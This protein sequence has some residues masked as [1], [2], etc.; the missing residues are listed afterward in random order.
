MIC[1]KKLKKKAM[2]ANN[3][4]SNNNVNKKYQSIKTFQ[5]IALTFFFYFI[6]S[7]NISINDTHLIGF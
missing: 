5:Q 6:H 1:K 3:K 4:F 2:R 7:M